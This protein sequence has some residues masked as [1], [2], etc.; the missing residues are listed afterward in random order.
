M[1]KV[2]TTT[3]VIK[4]LSLRTFHS[5]R[6]VKSGLQYAIETMVDDSIDTENVL[7]DFCITN[8][9]MA[10]P[11]EKD[12][13]SNT[14]I[15]AYTLIE[16]PAEN[17]GRMNIYADITHDPTQK[18]NYFLNLMTHFINKI[19]GYSEGMTYTTD[20]GTLEEIANE[21]RERVASALNGIIRR[22]ILGES[23][24]DEASLS[25][26]CYYLGLYLS[27]QSPQSYIKEVIIDSTSDTCIFIEKNNDQKR[28]GKIGDIWSEINSDGQ[29]GESLVRL[30]Q[31]GHPQD[32]PTQ[33]TP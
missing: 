29:P 7:F 16:E 6:A 31:L 18:A 22:R 32:P 15:P 5:F 26:K 30:L 13:L 17:P 23:D 8:F 27:T 24:D 11:D 28:Y 3:A 25:Q 1:D 4:A 14:G 33:A 21:R 20:C 10:V 19:R 12:I 9:L 2:L